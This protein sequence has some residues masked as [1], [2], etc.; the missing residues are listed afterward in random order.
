MPQGRNVNKQIS[1]INP[2]NSVY[3]NEIVWWHNLSAF[4]LRKSFP[5][6]CNNWIV[7]L[8]STLYYQAG[9]A[10][11]VLENWPLWPQS[12]CF[13]VIADHSHCSVSEI[14]DQPQEFYGRVTVQN[15]IFNTIERSTPNNGGAPSKTGMPKAGLLRFLQASG[16]FT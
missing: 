4:C 10:K 5:I 14:S 16:V 2:L 9:E 15:N 11:V 1:F 3:V 13:I 12:R 7:D 8:Y 6:D